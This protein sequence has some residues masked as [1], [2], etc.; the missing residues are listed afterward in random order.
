MYLD[1]LTLLQMQVGYG[2]LGM[3]GSLGYEGLTVSVRQQHYAHALSTHPPA[4]LRFQL[5]RSFA[6][7]TCQVALNDDVPAG[8]SHAHF[9]VR[10]DGVEVACVPYVMAGA[11][12]RD[13]CA[14][15]AGARVLELVVETDAWDFCHA[16]WLDPQVTEQPADMPAQ[17]LD[18]C[19][20]RAQ[21]EP[22]PP[23]PEV[24]CCV[25]TVASRGFESLLDDML[26]SLQVYGNC[27]DAQLI[28][29]GVEASDECRRI[30]EKYGA[31]FV[32][33][34][35]RAQVNSTI[36]S[37][38]YT[39]ARVV[40][41]RKF[42]C[43]DADMLVLGDLQPIFASIEV[44]PIG[45]VFAC[46]EAN[47]SRFTRL[48]RAIRTVYGGYPAD[49]TRLLGHQNGEGAYSLVVNDG[50]FAGGRTALLTLDGLIRSWTQAPGWVDERR[51]VWWR[52]QFIFNLALARL[53]CGIELDATY[54]VQLNSQN[55]C[56]QGANGRAQALWQ[57]RPVRVLHFNGNGRHKYP[58]WRG[59]F[60]RAPA[61]P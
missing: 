24:E 49:L 50:T 46:R 55:V 56:M 52:N 2:D 31:T 61:A 57:D 60:A 27:A 6:G 4:R 53:D 1:S 41:A 33:C 34:H 42:I 51:D 45:S 22:L 15:I 25:A 28:V 23:Q 13:L 59:R 18:D 19:L 40:P 10:A 16:L 17:T 32:V 48:D 35:R 14:N 3:H 43:L 7:F 21:I 37:I 26:G 8:R 5:D 39:S 44:A 38:L 11:P 30:A 20:G 58:E 12:P 36:K 54:N 29:F 47:G 9:F